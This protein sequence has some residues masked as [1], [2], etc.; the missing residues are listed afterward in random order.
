MLAITV[1]KSTIKK[2]LRT[3][4]LFY[5]FLLAVLDPVLLPLLLFDRVIFWLSFPGKKEKNILVSMY[6]NWISISMWKYDYKTQL[7]TH[8][9]ICQKY[10]QQIISKVKIIVPISLYNTTLLN[11]KKFQIGCL[12]YPLVPSNPSERTPFLYALTLE[13]MNITFLS[14]YLYNVPNPWLLLVG[15][16][17]LPRKVSTLFM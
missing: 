9:W 11:L 4:V 10:T 12:I 8:E 2:P 14:F 7:F 17:P 13:K 3:E 15:S 1:F 6:S 5:Y 16:F